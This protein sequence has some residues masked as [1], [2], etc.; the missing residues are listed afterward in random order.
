M[1]IFDGFKLIGLAIMAVLLIICGI[2]LVIDC[3]AYAVKK[4]QQKRIDDAF[5]ERE[6]PHEH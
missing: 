3:I 4:R 2:I 6:F 1:I 5:K